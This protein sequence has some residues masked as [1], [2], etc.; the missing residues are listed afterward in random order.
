[1]NDEAHEFIRGRMSHSAILICFWR[2]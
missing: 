2:P 1:M